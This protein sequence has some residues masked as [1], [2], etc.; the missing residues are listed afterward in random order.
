MKRGNPTFVAALLLRGFRCVVA[1]HSP[2]YHPLNLPIVNILA[3]KKFLHPGL[4][5]EE[6]FKAN[7]V[8]IQSELLV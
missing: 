7:L 5:N 2:D 1:A 8:F 6:I 4:T 3:E